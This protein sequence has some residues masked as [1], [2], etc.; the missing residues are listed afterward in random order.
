MSGFGFKSS[1][2]ALAFFPFFMYLAYNS[3]FL[4]KFAANFDG[5]GSEGIELFDGLDVE[6]SNNKL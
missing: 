3:G 4:C 6:K 2:V 1:I 5:N